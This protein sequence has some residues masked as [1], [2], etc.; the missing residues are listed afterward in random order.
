MVTAYFSYCSRLLTFSHHLTKLIVIYLC[1]AGE[2]HSLLSHSKPQCVYCYFPV[3]T[4]KYRSQ[5]FLQPNYFV[6]IKITVLENVTLYNNVCKIWNCVFEIHFY[7]WWFAHQNYRKHAQDDHG[8]L[9]TQVHV[10]WKHTKHFSM[11]IS[12]A[13]PHLICKYQNIFIQNQLNWQTH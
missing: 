3:N 8:L 4:Q 6:D 9:T 1:S 5:V 12:T 2:E 10:D 13:T 11:A 7:L